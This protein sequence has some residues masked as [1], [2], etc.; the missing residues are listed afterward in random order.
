M[1]SGSTINGENPNPV[2]STQ[3]TPLQ[4]ATHSLAPAEKP[5]KFSGVDFKRWQQKMYFYLTTLGLQKFIK[6]V[7]PNPNEEVP[8]KDRFLAIEAWKHSD[9]L[10]KNYILNGLDD[11][12]YNVY[13]T[14]ETSKE[15][16][17]ALEK[18]YKAEDAGLKKS[19]AAKF[20][21]YKMVDSKAVVTQVQELQVITHD[22]LNEGMII[23]EAFQVA[24][25]IEKLP[26]AWKDFKSYLKHKR[27]EMTLED[28]IVRLKI[29]E[30][31]RLAEKKSRGQSTI[32]G[33]NIMESDSKGKKR[34]RDSVPSSSGT[35][36]HNGNKKINGTCF[37]CG[38]QGHKA[39]MCKTHKK[40]KNKSQANIVDDTDMDDLCAVLSEC[41]L[42]GNPR[43][44]WIDSGATRHVCAVKEMFTSY[45]LAKA[46]EKLFMGNSSTAKV[47]GYGKIVLKMTS[48]K[49][50]TLNNVLHVPEIRKNLV[51]TSLLAKHGFKVVFVSDKVVIS[52]ND[53]YIGKGY[54][55]NDLFKLNV[56]TVNDVINNNN[57][58]SAY[59]LESNHLW[60][61]RLGHV[62][63]KSLRKM[64]NMEV[65]PKF[66]C[67]KSKCQVCVESKFA[68]HPYKSI[69]RTSEPLDLIHTD[70]CDMKSTP[71]RGGKKYFITFIDDSTR[72][73]YVYLLSSKDEAIDAFKQFKA[74][75]ENQLNKKIKMARSDRGGEYEFPFEE[76]C[77]EN[78]IIHQTSAPYTPQKNGVAER[79]NRTL[80]D[81]MNALLLNSA[82]P[83]NLWGEAILIA[84]QILNRVPY[85]KTQTIPY[86]K[87]KGK[88]PNLNYFK[89]W[90]CLAKVRVPK[91]KQVKL[92]PKT[93]DCIFIGY[94]N[95]SKAYRFLVYKSQISDIHPN[96][97]IESD[98]AEFFENIFPYRNKD[99][100]VGES[101]KRPRDDSLENDSNI[102][103][104]WRSK[105][106]R[107]PT[108]FGPD[109]LAFC[110]KMSQRH[111]KKR[112]GFGASWKMFRFGPSR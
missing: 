94:A 79:K 25:F 46:E 41:N 67:N 20:L 86:E 70:I 26:P 29:E 60:H 28:L 72:Y 17:E 4:V 85:S 81:M 23:N 52:K 16:W 12:L 45:S 83:Q 50:V 2:T 30:D 10:C 6:E 22:L 32:S 8:E 100:V 107:V 35:K 53:V 49:V 68:K 13:S 5:G 64:I 112:N 31:D 40:K 62:N 105:R 9:F 57:A 33:A 24:S 66:E 39:S 96:T 15:L 19:I 108:S 7:I 71:S 73:C 74:E 51:S 82:L 97:V 61:A 80:K 102:D 69:E 59:L 44:W 75:V 111:L 109:F 89:V 48:G 18:K 103:E 37:K 36:N 54:L 21:E 93:I 14:I 84:T 63:Y 92:G 88:R 104:P 77:L 98:S 87:W 11:I 34:K 58:S 47:E 56:I 27:K 3:S 101:S 90:G 110:W 99:V 1:S 65:L 78:G 42:V 55:N 95:N 76:I 106:Q 43:E 91:P 38:K